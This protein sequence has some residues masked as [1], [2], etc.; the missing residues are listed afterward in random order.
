MDEVAHLLK[1]DVL[2]TDLASEQG[3]IKKLQKHA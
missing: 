3:M 2:R 1:N